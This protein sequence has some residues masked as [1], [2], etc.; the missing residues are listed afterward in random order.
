MKMLRGIELRYLHL[1]PAA[2]G[3]DEPD[4]WKRLEALPREQRLQLSKTLEEEFDALPSAE[5]SAIRE[6]DAAL[7]KLPPEVQARY[8]VVLRRYHVGA[9]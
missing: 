6:L 4:N 3:A 7:A 1:T 2:G 8:R 9:T 5:R